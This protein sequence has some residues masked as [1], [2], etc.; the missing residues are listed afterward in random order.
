MCLAPHP[1][2]HAHTFHFGGFQSLVE[3][4]GDTEHFHLSVI[5]WIKGTSTQTLPAE[6]T[7]LSLHQSNSINCR[8]LPNN[9]FLSFLLCVFAELPRLP[10]PHK[11][12]RGKVRERHRRRC[13]V[14][15]HCQ[16]SLHPA[17]RFLPLN[18]TRPG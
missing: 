6:H 10:S 4:L 14:H 13:Y 3:Q 7:A 17:Y 15:A 16:Q 1:R 8:Y 5:V 9:F 12:C 18:R 2:T 11:R